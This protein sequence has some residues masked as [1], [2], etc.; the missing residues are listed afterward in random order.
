MRSATFLIFFSI[1]LLI[2]SSVNYYLYVRGLQ[3]FSLSQ[4]MKRWYIAVFWVVASMFIV[5]SVLERT[6]SSAF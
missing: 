2:Y 5:G 4:P 3:A 6:A 1:V